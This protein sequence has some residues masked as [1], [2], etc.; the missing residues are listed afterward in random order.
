MTSPCL[1][2]QRAPW[3]AQTASLPDRAEMSL[4]AILTRTNLAQ[5]AV[6][7]R[8]WLQLT[9]HL[10]SVFLQSA[11]EAL[12]MKVSLYPRMQTLMYAY[13]QAHMPS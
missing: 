6:S 1:A 3:Q 2:L 12:R 11:L 5:A 8:L 4:L 13:T 9:F 10:V 7:S